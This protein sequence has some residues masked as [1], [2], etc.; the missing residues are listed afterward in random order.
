MTDPIPLRPRPDVQAFLATRRSRPAKTLGGE[1]PD[2]AALEALLMAAARVP[3]HGKL[4]PWRFAVLGSK[5]RAAMAAAAHA[6]GPDAGLDAAATEK[7]ALQFSYGGAVVAVVASAVVPH[8]IPAWEQELSAGAV[9]LS[10]VNAALAAGW[11]ANWLTGPFARHTGFLQST[12]GTQ[13][14]EFVAGFI[15]IGNETVVP[16]DRDRPDLRKCVDWLE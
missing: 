4:A 11:G 10:L 7:A 8:K 16:A 1:A 5:T 9:C 14:G 6:H 15:H 13:P 2:R 12:L 3:D